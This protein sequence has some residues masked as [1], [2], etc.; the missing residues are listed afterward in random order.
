[1][2]PSL[3]KKLYHYLL[4]QGASDVGFSMPPDAE[5]AFPGL[6]YAVSIVVHLSDFIVDEID[7]APTHTY[8]NHYRSVNTLLDQLLLKTG[9]FLQKEGYRYCTVAASQSNNK[10]GWNY[11]G[12][13]SHKKAATLAGLGTVGKSSLF[14]HKQWGPRV[15]LATLFTDCPFTVP[16]SI[17]PSPCQNCHLCVDACPSGAISGKTWSPE[18]TREEM[19]V[20]EKCSNYMK[21]AFQ[22]IGRG[23]VCGICIRVCPMAKGLPVHKTE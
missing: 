18:R 20:P 4:E 5:T 12:R 16:E 6:P 19:F 22:H 8:F 15:R 17:L 9:L 23:A 3:Q 11:Q 7:G 21:R 13:Y 10:D 1:M 2:N 14:L